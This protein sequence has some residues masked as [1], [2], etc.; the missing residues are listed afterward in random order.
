MLGAEISEIAVSGDAQNS[1]RFT[2]FKPRASASYDL[3]LGATASLGVERRI[4]QLDFG[5]F[6]ASAGLFDGVSTAGNP[7][8]GPEIA[9]VDSFDLDWRCDDGFAAPLEAFYRE[10][11]GVLEHVA[12]PSGGLGIAKAGPATVT[13]LVVTID[14]PLDMVISGEEFSLYG[15]SN[16]SVVRDPLINRDRAFNQFRR[17]LC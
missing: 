4:G 16:D 10:R 14:L 11:E 3:G 2:F 12:L 7:A 9:W 13:G 15:E 8:L 17:L 6:A 1:Q 5:D